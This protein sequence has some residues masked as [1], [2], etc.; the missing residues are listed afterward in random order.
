MPIRGQLCAPIDTDVRRA[1]RQQ[2][3]ATIVAELW[4]FWEQELARISGKSKL[5][6][7]IRYARMQI[8]REV[9]PRFRDDVAPLC[10]AVTK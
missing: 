3:S 7:A 1:V 8:P 6:E 5:A 2:Q 4:P 10:R 9:A